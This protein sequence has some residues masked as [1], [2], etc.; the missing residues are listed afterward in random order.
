MMAWRGRRGLMAWVGAALLCA[1]IAKTTPA[2]NKAEE[3]KAPQEIAPK[4]RDGVQL[5]ATFYPPNKPG[6]D[7]VPVI[8]LHG[9]KGSQADMK[10]L[11]ERLQDA[12]HAA[13]A[14]DL[15]GHGGSTRQTLPNGRERIIEPARLNRADFE[16]MFLY[17]VESCKRFLMSLNNKGELNINKLCIVGA[18]L[19]A[20]V[21]VNWAIVDWS[22]PPL[23]VGKQGQ[24]VK[25][26]VLLSPPKT[27][28]GLTIMPALGKR[29][30]VDKISWLVV[31]GEQEPDVRDAKAVANQLDKWLPEPPPDQAKEKQ[32]FYIEVLPTNL[33][34]AKLLAAEN[35]GLADKI[36]IFIDR[37]LVTK[38]F[39]WAD[40]KMIP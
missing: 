21:A 34:G 20:I 40:R 23:A 38:P 25:A 32:A 33:Q 5:A 18:D 12:G 28:R 9:Y 24:D 7:V 26:I 19:G 10:G 37:R 35:F 31:Y 14:L 22:W 16:G 11:A 36:M 8:L 30:I 27:V 15:R 29:D 39:P 13:I 6:K 1:S 4:T 2:Q 3:R 17:D